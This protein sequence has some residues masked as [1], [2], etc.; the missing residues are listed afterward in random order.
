MIQ[1]PG[2][3]PIRI[4]PVFWLLILFIGWINSGTVFGTVIWG[5][6]IVFSILVHEYG[7][8]ITARAFGQEAAID[9][10]GLGGLT[11]RSGD[12]LSG[13]SE[14]FV[15]LNGPLFGF[16]LF[17]LAYLIRIYWIG[18][19][20]LM[21]DILDILVNVNLF[22]NILNLLPVLP[23]DGGHLM[24]IALESMFG[25]NGL[26]SAML[27][28]LMLGV[29]LGLF[30]FAIQSFIAGALFFM[31]AF[32]SYRNWAEVKSMTPQD[33]DVQ[34]QESLQDAQQDLQEGRQE[35]AFAKLQAIR[36]QAKSGMLYVSAT[37][38]VSRL[39]AE[40]GLWKQ[41]YEMLFPLQTQLDPSYLRFLQQL[42][43]RLQEW[44]QTV[45]IGNRAYQQ[46][47]TSETALLNGLSYAIM[48]QARP[49]VGW[50]RSAIKLGLPNPS[51]ILAKREFD[52][53][54]QSPE[55]KSLINSDF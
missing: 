42:S 12:R 55:F 40:K 6:V 34:L 19:A 29:L 28:S 16:L 37:Q 25:I 11:R 18:T 24:R 3:I 21:R 26:K 38:L 46:E 41:A 50:I 2:T 10:V 53:I 51:Q 1:I 4:F 23:L 30:F 13:W 48:G 44:E 52:V 32:E 8:A 14:F 9:L 22:W 45:K 20:P 39:L 27:I 49:A 33:R 36:Q 47:P 35:E 15:V 54:R 17:Y 31:L 5:I 43:Y 7:H